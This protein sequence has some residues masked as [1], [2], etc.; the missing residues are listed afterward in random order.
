MTELLLNDAGVPTEQADGKLFWIG[1]DNRGRELE[2]VGV[3]LPDE[4]IVL[5]IHIMPTI[6]PK[7]K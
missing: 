5:V 7:G 4:D 1:T 3:P 2:V 6:Y